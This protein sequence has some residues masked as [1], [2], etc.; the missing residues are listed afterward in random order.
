M[1]RVTFHKTDATD[2]EATCWNCGTAVG[3]AVEARFLYRRSQ[4][5]VFDEWI[6]CPCGAYQNVMRERSVSIEPLTGREGGG[7]G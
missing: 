2:T 4:R 7:T 5:V 3:G 6:A 1:E